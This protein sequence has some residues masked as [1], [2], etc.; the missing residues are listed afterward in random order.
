[1]PVRSFVFVRSIVLSLALFA[2]SHA[3]ESD[4]LDDLLRAAH[5]AGLRLALVTGSP[6]PLPEIALDRCGWPEMVGNVGGDWVDTL[7]VGGA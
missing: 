1:M 2:A 6:P 5:A 4:G 7:P 3:E